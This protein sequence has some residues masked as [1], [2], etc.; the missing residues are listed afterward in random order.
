MFVWASSRCKFSRRKRIV[1]NCSLRSTSTEK[2]TFSEA[3]NKVLL[4][5]PTGFW[6]EMLVWK[7]ARSTANKVRKPIVCSVIQLKVRKPTCQK[8]SSLSSTA[9]CHCRVLRKLIQPSHVCA[10]AKAKTALSRWE[11]HPQT[12]ANWSL[13]PLFFCT[14]FVYFDL[15]NSIVSHCNLASIMSAFYVYSLVQWSLLSDVTGCTWITSIQ[16]R[17]RPIPLHQAVL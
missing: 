7:R 11:Y 10:R 15:K 9:V 16:S 17:L 1:A 2:L 13:W 14:N 6:I 3:R 5:K 12:S 4:W 8:T